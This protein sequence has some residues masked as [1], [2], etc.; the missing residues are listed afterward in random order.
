[1]IQNESSN[2]NTNV[3][4][5]TLA[6]NGK[7]D[8]EITMEQFI[9][10]VFLKTLLATADAKD[11]NLSSKDLMTSYSQAKSKD[12]RKRLFQRIIQKGKQSI[13]EK[14]DKGWEETPDGL[15]PLSEIQ[16]AGY[17]KKD[18]A[19]FIPVEAYIVENANSIY[20]KGDKYIGVAKQYLDWRRRRKEKA[21]G[22]IDY[23]IDQEINKE[24]F[25]L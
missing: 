12:E 23:Y 8:K 5:I 13:Q 19:Y 20:R 6:P 9:K 7:K 25:N 3:K 17:I 14:L 21:E 16:K 10:I 11:R 4:F 22:N 18:G 24:F 1:M 15:L 2:S